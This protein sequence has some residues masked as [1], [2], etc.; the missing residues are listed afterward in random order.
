MHSSGIS[1]SYPRDILEMSLSQVYQRYITGITWAHLRPFKEDLNT[2]Y[3]FQT[4]LNPICHGL[5]GPDRFPGGV[6]SARYSIQ[7]TIL[8]MFQILLLQGLRYVYKGLETKK[9]GP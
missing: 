4:Y 6:Q 5:L 1:Q 9:R 8:M 2:R 7:P 3:T